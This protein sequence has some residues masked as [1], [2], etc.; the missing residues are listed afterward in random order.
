ML[1]FYIPPC[2]KTFPAWRNVIYQHGRGNKCSGTNRVF[3]HSQNCNFPEE[4]FVLS[5]FCNSARISSW[6]ARSVHASVPY[7]HGQHVL[8]ALVKYGIFTLMLSI[9][10]RNW[11]ICCAGTHQFLMCMLRETQQFLTRML[12]VHISSWCVC[13][14][15][16]EGTALLKIRLSIRIRKVAAPNEPQNIVLKFC[17]TPKSPPKSH[18]WAALIRKIAKFDCF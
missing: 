2:R 5:T 12:R 16:F 7:T 1:L 17:L 3:S 6:C 13:S 18:T 8:K 14:A 10:V 4:G 9:H 15:C 11:C